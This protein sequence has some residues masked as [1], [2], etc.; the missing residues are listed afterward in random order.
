MYLRMRNIL[1]CL[2]DN[3]NLIVR[4]IINFNMI[5]YVIDYEDRI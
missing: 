2:I 5:N 1:Y 3:F 4:M